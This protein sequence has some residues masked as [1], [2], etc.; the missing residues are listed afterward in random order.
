MCPKTVY[1]AISMNRLYYAQ[2]PFSKYP[3]IFEN[4]DFVSVLAFRPHVNCV[5][6]HKNRRF[7]KTV[8]RM[9]FFKIASLRLVFTSDG[10]G[11]GDVSEVVRALIKHHNNNNNNK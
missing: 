1:D 10:V 4:G 3:Y 8:P 2:A 11:V 7:S 5:L 6:G 9:E